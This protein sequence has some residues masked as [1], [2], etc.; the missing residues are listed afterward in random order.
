MGCTRLFRQPCFVF[1]FTIFTVKHYLFI[2]SFMS[3]RIK[4]SLTF[5]NNLNKIPLSA[6]AVDCLFSSATF[7][8]E[9]LT[10]IANAQTRIYLAA[11]YL[12]AD[13]AGNEVLQ[14]LYD[15]KKNK[16]NLDI[17]VCIDFH[18]AQRGL[19]GNKKNKDTNATWYHAMMQSNGTGIKIVGIPVK[20]KELFGVQHLKGFIFDDQILY[21]GASFNDIYLHHHDRYRFDRYWLI[22][23]AELAD[24]MVNYLKDEV[25]NRVAVASLNDENIPKVSEFKTAQK[26]L[27]K[28]LKKAT[29]QFN[30]QTSVDSLSVLP[31]SGLGSKKNK[32]NDCIRNVLHST[33]NELII[34]TPY[35]NLPALLDR[36]IATI[37]NRGV[38]ITIV[39]GDKTANDFYIAEDK[40]F[41]TIGGLPYLYETNLKRFAE[42]HRSALANGQLKLHLWKHADN[43]F[44]LK[45][46]YSDQRFILLTGHNLNPRAWRLD[47]ENGLLIDDPKQTLK[48]LLDKELNNILQHTSQIMSPEQ[49]QGVKDYP[50]HI[51]KLLQRMRR[52]KV[53]KLV[54]GII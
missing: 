46:V 50:A 14:A 20:R 26:Q 47:L 38:Q 22:K 4:R 48:P 1:V 32:L 24:S 30:G 31:L 39:V 19:I 27:T 43:S 40:P 42:K 37:M 49:I 12:E 34:F 21:S 33:E 5:L 17:V 44:H 13:Q 29:Y 41:K 36:D 6:D 15:A 53:D 16:P 2:K 25:I 45:G 51:K 35:F 3:N 23:N 28:H 54:K 52:I 9:L 8:S 7:K 10:Q 11:L 18:R